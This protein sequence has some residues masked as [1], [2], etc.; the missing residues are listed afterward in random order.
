MLGRRE[1]D[2]LESE[3]EREMEDDVEGLGVCC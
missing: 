2:V 1:L 3:W